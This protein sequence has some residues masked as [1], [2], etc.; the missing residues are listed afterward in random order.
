VTGNSKARGDGTEAAVLRS[1]VGAGYSVSIPF[2]DNDKYDLIVDD[3]AEIRRIQCKT[4][5]QNKPETIRFNTHSQTTRDGSYH[6]QTYEGAAD[7]FVVR[8][9]VTGQL[10]WVDVEDATAQKMEL[11]FEADID[12]PAINWAS[13]Y[14]FDGTL[15]P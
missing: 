7:A 14:E 5:W 12:H 6:E 10:Y 8:Y 4:A 9:P 1:L 15:P 11:R 3:G 13:E 2:G